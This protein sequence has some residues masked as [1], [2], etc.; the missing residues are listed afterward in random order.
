VASECKAGLFIGVNGYPSLASDR[1]LDHAAEDAKWL[2]GYFRRASLDGHWECPEGPATRLAVL[3][4]VAHLVQNVG[5]DGVGLFHFAGHAAHH[6]AGL[7]LATSDFDPGMPA[8]S[9]VPLRRILD[10]F[11]AEAARGRRFLAILDCC[12]DGAGQDLA[13]DDIPQ[14]VCVLYS[15]AQGD[16]ASEGADGGLLT[17]AI[18][19]ALRRHTQEVGDHVPCTL[20]RLHTRLKAHLV[21]SIVAPNPSYELYGGH[22]D[23]LQLPIVLRA[24]QPPASPSIRPTCIV[25]TVPQGGQ[26]LEALRREFA[27]FLSTWFEISQG[28]VRAKTLSRRHLTTSQKEGRL[29]LVLPDDTQFWGTRE[30]LDRLLEKFYGHFQSLVVTWSRP[31]P[32]EYFRVLQRHVPNPI[33]NWAGL[34]EGG[35]TL[36]WWNNRGGSRT[37]GYIFLDHPT[38]DVTEIHIT[39]QHPSDTGNLPL[40]FLQPSLGDLFD[41]L[42]LASPPLQEDQPCHPT[43]SSSN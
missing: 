18:L 21:D 24:D 40:H 26:T 27:D 35:L 33:D 20:R 25:R 12:R 34:P 43:Q 22:A 41:R 16:M 30:F 23:R 15:C 32:V 13:A 7:V 11:K 1:W 31:I 14:N 5:K 39:C 9:G 36:S 19:K 42:R 3:N 4:W 17:R 38:R 6:G 10:L 28:D 8:D 37:R 29:S 2:G